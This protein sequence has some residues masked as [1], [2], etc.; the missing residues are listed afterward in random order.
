MDK[1]GVLELNKLPETIHFT[2]DINMQKPKTESRIQ[3]IDRAAMLLD[4]LSRYS[5]PVKLKALSADTN[6]APST[7]YRSRKALV[8]NGFI[9]RNESSEYQLSLQLLKM[10]RRLNTHVKLREVA[11]PYMEALRDKTGETINVTSR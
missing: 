2:A 6:L 7:A 11:L 1:L 8:D 10:S 3:V 5:I 4:T 9:D